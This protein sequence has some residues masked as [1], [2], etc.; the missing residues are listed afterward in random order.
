MGKLT[1]LGRSVVLARS[2]RTRAGTASLLDA[3]RPALVNLALQSLLGGISLIG[4]DHLDEAE[5]TRLL[6]VGI[7][8]DIALLDFSVLAEKTSYLLLGQAGVDAGDEQ[9]GA[10]IAGAFVLIVLAALWRWTTASYVSLPLSNTPRREKQLTGHRG[11]W[12]RR[13]GRACRPDRG[14]ES[15]SAHDRNHGARLL[16]LANGRHAQSWPTSLTIVA[17]LLT[18]VLH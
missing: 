18:L 16:G 15:G 12:E 5:A 10:G 8:H 4:R 6:G 9:V 14:E 1:A 2:R 7:L 13:C 17:T 3:Q 11:H